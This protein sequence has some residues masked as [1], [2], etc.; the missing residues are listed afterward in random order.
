MPSLSLEEGGS[1]TGVG[2]GLLDENGS[3]M[4]AGLAGCGPLG[5]HGLPCGS[6]PFGGGGYGLSAVHGTSAGHGS[7]GT[8]CLPGGIGLLPDGSAAPVGSPFPCGPPVVTFS[9]WLLSLASGLSSSLS[10]EG[11]PFCRDFH[12]RSISSVILLK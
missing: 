4:G 6:R 11:R 2:C 9:S 10:G 12:S 1:C 8:Y 3:P 5:G 7:S